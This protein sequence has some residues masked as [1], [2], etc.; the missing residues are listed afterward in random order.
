MAT[1]G[2]TQPP[3]VHGRGVSSG[4]GGGFASSFPTPALLQRIFASVGGTG[5]S[6]L[7]TANS[8]AST[9]VAARLEA[10]RVTPGG[11]SSSGGRRGVQW[12]GAQ[13]R[14]EEGGGGG[15]GGGAGGASEDGDGAGSCCSGGGGIAAAMQG[16]QPSCA[17]WHDSVTILFADICSFTTLSQQVRRRGG[18]RGGCVDCAVLCDNMAVQQYDVCALKLLLISRQVGCLLKGQ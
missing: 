18:R 16:L 13:G 5:R 15:G 4:G 9:D 3:S 2:G 12:V 14:P 10:D 7:S 11:V 8:T 1:P 17:E 6:S